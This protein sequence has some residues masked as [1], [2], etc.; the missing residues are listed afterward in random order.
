MDLK[1]YFEDARGTGVLSTADGQGRVNV[2]VYARPHVM[3]D[4]TLAFIM[5]DRL[6]RHN[7]E[8]NPNA[9]Y[10]F[11][12]D[13]TERAGI[14]LNLTKVRESEDADLIARLRRRSYPPEDE[15]GMGK[16][17]LVY[18]TVEHQRPLVGAPRETPG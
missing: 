1:K 3:E 6:S 17:R 15:A 9:A 10:L 7:V 12:E 4:G 13:K 11:L 5:S 2:A 14:R 16:L 8:Q 18:F